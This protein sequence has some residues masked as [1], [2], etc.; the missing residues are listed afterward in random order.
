METFV[1]VD[2]EEAELEH[3]QFIIQWVT[4]NEFITISDNDQLEEI[5]RMY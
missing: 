3:N 2:S 4:H 1:L 5:Y